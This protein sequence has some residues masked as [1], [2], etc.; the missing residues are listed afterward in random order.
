MAPAMTNKLAGTFRSLHVR[1]YRLFATGQVV[2]LFGNWMQ[3]TAQDW[4]VLKLSD[5]SG[6]ALGVVTALQ[7]T[8]A[9]LFS[10]YAGK[11]ADRHDKRRLLIGANAAAGLLALV[12]GLLVVTGSAQLWHVFVFA[13]CLGTVNAIDVPT[14]QAFISEMVKPD[15]LPNA[16]SLNS[17]TFNMARTVGPAIAGVTIAL[18]GTG[19]VF[20]VNGVT[21]IAT[22]V[23]LLAMNVAQLHRCERSAV[24]KS[25]VRD[26]LRYTLGRPDLMLPMALMFVIGGFAFKFQLT[27]AMLSKTVFDRGAASFG[28]LTSALALGALVGSLASSR[29]TGRPTVYTLIGGAVA[30]GLFEVLVG[31]TPSYLIAALVLLPTG[32]SMIYLAQAAN[33]RVQ[34]GVDDA[35]RGRVMALYFLLFQ[36]ATPVFAPLVGWLSEH[37]GG[38]SPLIIGGIAAVLVALAVLAVRSKRRG[39]RVRLHVRPLPH[40]RFVEPSL[41]RGVAELGIPAPPVRAVR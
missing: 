4:L 1:N 18:I 12:L 35:Y 16:A 27:L 10:L 28:L 21:Y 14:R 38:R 41:S 9:L 5:D 13:T 7:F 26:G 36:G 6:T 32:F 33:Q 8:P 25:S 30:F 37:V 22:I 3:I 31:L 29:R 20:I 17:A 11:L 23:A 39:V 34:L 40:L 15:L 19:P 2:S 24:G